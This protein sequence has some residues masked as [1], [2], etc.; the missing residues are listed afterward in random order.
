MPQQ[1]KYTIIMVL[2]IKRDRTE[3]GN[4]RGISMLAYSG[5]ILLTIFVRHLS[6]YYN[7]VRILPDNQIGFRPNSSITDIMFGIRRLQELAWK[8]RIML[9]T[10]FSD[11]IKAYDSVYQ[12]F[13]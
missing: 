11:V 8:K 12:T 10:Y 5:R 1:W 13:V 7:R 6:E 2:H 9:Y 3:W 4:Y